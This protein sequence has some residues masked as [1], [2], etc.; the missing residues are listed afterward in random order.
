MKY[1]MRK[2]SLSKSISS[3]TTGKMTRAVKKSVSPLYGKKG[4]GVIKNP[5]KALK[6]RVYHK[7]TFGISD[8][9]NSSGKSSS[10]SNN[11]GSGYSKRTSM[12]LVDLKCPNCGANLQ[13]NSELKKL[14]VITVGKI[15]PSMT[16]SSTFSMIMLNKLAMSL[17]KDVNAPWK[18]I[19]PQW[20][21]PRANQI[22]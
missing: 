2:P 1:G 4:M 8:I 18:N 6:N 20:L 19:G 10:R 12:K 5:E 17:R 14:P 11:V 13:V 16:R 21:T 7:T 22:L 3:R 15:L 9:A